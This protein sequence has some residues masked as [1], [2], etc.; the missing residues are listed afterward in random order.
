MSKYP[1]R[2]RPFTALS[3][4]PPAL[5]PLD[6]LVLV[7]VAAAVDPRTGITDPIVANLG[8]LAYRT[9]AARSSIGNTLSRLVELGLLERA[10]ERAHRGYPMTYRVPGLRRG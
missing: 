4:V 2:L 6:R 9:G 5:T 1:E 3:D 8:T 7:L 10:A